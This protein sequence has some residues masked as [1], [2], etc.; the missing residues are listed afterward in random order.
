MDTTQK[1]EIITAINSSADSIINAV[2]GVDVR[3][4]QN[5]E[6]KLDEIIVLLQEIS[7]KLEP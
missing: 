5:I 2:N 1:N 3:I 6:K 4:E 7:N